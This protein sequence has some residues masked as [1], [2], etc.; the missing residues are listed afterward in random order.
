MSLKKDLAYGAVELAKSQGASY[1]DIRVI[2][3]KSEIIQTRNGIIAGVE[4]H[5]SL[6][7]G[8]RVI[9]DGAWGFAA[10]NDYT[11]SSVEVA[12]QRAIKIAKS[13]SS[14]AT[15]RVHLAPEERYIA[16]WTT[17]HIIDPFTI[18][19]ENKIELLLQVDEILRKTQGITLT[20]TH[21]NFRDKKQLFL[22]SDG[23]EI[24]QHIIWSGAG[25]AATASDGSEN[26]TRSYP[27]SHGG[28]NCSKGY[29]LISELKLVG[30]A[31][32]IAEEAVMLL[33][34]PQCPQGEMDIIIGSSQMALQIHES[35]GHP[36]ELDRALGMEANFAGTS[37]LTPDKLGKLAYGSKIV[38]IV[39]DSTS[40]A[41]LGTFGYDDEGVPAQKWDIIKQ[42]AF[43]GYLASRETA[44]IIGLEKSN[45]TLRADGYN[46]FPIIR[47]VNVNLMP[48]NWE[49][50]NLIADTKNGILVDSNKS[51][52]I[53]QQRLN[54]QF[55]TEMGWRIKDGKIAGPLKNCT[56]Q[57]IT[58]KFWNS[59]DAI[60]NMDSWQL[61]GVPN[62]GKG[63]PGQTMAV[64]HGA[65]PARFRQVLVGAGYG[66]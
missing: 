53:D 14:F 24:E 42:G 38:N 56:Y 58:Y 64:S 48:G 4:K 13:G 31:P 49:Y 35:C 43:V 52:S 46:R 8:I 32:R 11:K 5:E 62:C 20:N 33:K 55:A 9:V 63:E 6:G 25:F 65:S 15:K 30:N 19:T 2:L 34:A 17:P 29:E 54:F 28:Q 57:G 60:C 18:P 45:G 41:G 12:T 16:K 50:D 59:C 22:N 26:Q 23:S 7:F 47:M 37:F 27:Q 51:W 36:I 66:K 3:V 44:S 10:A 61:W 40:P 1:S 39:A 21:M